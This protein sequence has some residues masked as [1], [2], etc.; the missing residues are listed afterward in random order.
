MAENRV[1][2]LAAL[3]VMQHSA[4]SID[5]GAREPPGDVWFLKIRCGPAS[6]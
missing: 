5:A 4:I 6:A 3:A 2:Q 1:S